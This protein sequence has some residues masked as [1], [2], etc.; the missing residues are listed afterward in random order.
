MY[1]N[2]LKINVNQSFS[3]DNLINVNWEEQTIIVELINLYLPEHIREILPTNE[4]NTYSITWDKVESY[5]RFV[6]EDL[7]AKLKKLLDNFQITL[8]FLER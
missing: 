1:K 6:S 2:N 3:K 7:F 4:P 8:E 5:D